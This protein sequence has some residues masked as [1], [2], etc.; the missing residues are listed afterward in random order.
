[1]NLKKKMMNQMDKIKKALI[2]YYEHGDWIYK[3]INLF[4][5]F[6]ACVFLF[7]WVNINLDVAVFI[8]FWAT[9]AIGIIK[10][11]GDGL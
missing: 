1:M 9:V 6:I 11:V 8:S 4:L 10:L 5:I 7:F 3:G 2:D